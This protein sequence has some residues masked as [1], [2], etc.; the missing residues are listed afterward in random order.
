MREG[1]GRVG[2]YLRETRVFRNL[3]CM[4]VHPS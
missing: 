2:T 4:A 3:G 1:G